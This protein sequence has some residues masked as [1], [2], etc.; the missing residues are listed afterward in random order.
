MREPGPNDHHIELGRNGEEHLVPGLG[1]EYEFS[2]E[3]TGEAYAEPTPKEG[4]LRKRAQALSLAEEELEKE[5]ALVRR[6]RRELAE[7][8]KALEASAGAS[9]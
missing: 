2:R 6:E 7:R 5:R 9:S 8:K 3:R 1:P 4:Q